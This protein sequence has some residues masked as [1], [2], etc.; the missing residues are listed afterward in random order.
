MKKSGSGD[1]SASGTGG[2]GFR[3][4]WWVGSMGAGAEARART[5]ISTCT[6]R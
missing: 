1:G 2:W 6:V 5:V 3:K 4:I